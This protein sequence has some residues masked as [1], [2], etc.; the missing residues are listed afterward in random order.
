MPLLALLFVGPVFAAGTPLV[1]TSN[2]AVLHTSTP[3][4]Q[5]SLLGTGF[6]PNAQKGGV[7]FCASATLGTLL[8]YSPAMLK[9]A[10]NF[11]STNGFGGLDG[12]GSTI[13][14]VD[15]F[16][17]PT[18]RSD[19]NYF[20]KTFGLPAVQLTILCGPTW[21]GAKTDVCPLNTVADITTVGM[22]AAGEA[23]GGPNGVTGWAEETS[24]DVAMAHS[25]APAAKIVL[26]V[27]NDC[28]DTSLYGAENAVVNQPKYQGSIMSQSFG[29]PDD[30]VTCTALDPT[31]TYCVSYDPTLLNLPNSVFQTAIKNHWTII[32][33]S[34]DSG[35][36]EDA[37]VLGTGELTPS[38]PATS[39]LVL[40]AGGTEGNPYGGQ[41]GLPP[42]LGGTEGCPA[43]TYCNTGLVIINGGANGC[44]TAARPGTPTSC[45]AVGYGGEAAWN[46]F[47]TL[48]DFGTTT[49]GGVS[50]LYS[51]PSYQ[52]TTP[53]TYATL[54]GHK[55]VA[56]GRTTPDVSFNSAA[57]GGFLVPLG[58]IPNPCTSSVCPGPDWA[59]FSGTS[60]ASPA[61]AG[62]LALL[63]EAN[64]SPVGFINQEIYT[65]GAS[66]QGFGSFGSGPFHDIT[67][68]ENSFTGG[69]TSILT[70]CPPP[71]NTSPKLPLPACAL[72][73]F[74]ATHGYDLTTGWGSP[75]VAVFIQSML[76]LIPGHH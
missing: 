66:A 33:S 47:P 70:V 6:D 27:A 23:C 5:V 46:E 63:N 49:G 39:P 21:T 38:F 3:F 56:T 74:T 4:L 2:T 9:T 71:F 67:T 31:Y 28:Y 17:S 34:G 30:L 65:L 40:A 60:A 36:N 12:K 61:W 7:P 62:I 73:G 64:G 35:A 10:Y 8:C 19:I 75:N 22:T 41:Y 26:V 53:R 11:P 15:A 72:D 43:H 32:A 13:V 18:I 37:E 14:I 1:S 68:G 69:S 59:V 57:Q 16:G 52:F 54:L 42:G 29:E 55:V 51:R 76:P 20:D 44:G 48:G 24:L 25:L 50:G 58:F 45:Y